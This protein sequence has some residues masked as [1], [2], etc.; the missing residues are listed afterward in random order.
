MKSEIERSLPVIPESDI[1]REDGRKSLTELWETYLTLIDK[2]WIGEII[3]SQEITLPDGSMAELP[4]FAFRTPLPAGKSEE[5]LWV[6]GGVHGEE[7]A[8]P[9][10]FSQKIDSIDHLREFGIPVVFIP[11]MNPAGY[12][13]DWRYEDERRDFTKGH[14]VSDSEHMLLAENSR[15]RTDP[16]ASK[17]ADQIT[18]WIER[19]VSAYYPKLVIDH[20]ED[21]VPEKFPEGDPRNITSCYVYASG[22]GSHTAD[23]AQAVNRLFIESGLPVIDQ[24]TTRFGEQ[25]I[26]GVVANAADGSIDEFLSSAKYFSRSENRIKDKFPASTS[27][28]VETTIPFD[29]SIPL[30]DRVRAHGKIVDSYLPFWQLVKS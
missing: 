30:I 26:S 11:L 25:I 6:L 27:I 12:F 5:A 21:R 22:Q 3:A 14:S 28:V 10:A 8:G 13:R 18:S 23:I 19:S 9:N 29:G 20:H 24:G 4:I 15:P 16:P 7:P 17:T 1:Y 2:G